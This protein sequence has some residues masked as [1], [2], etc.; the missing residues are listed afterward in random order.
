M[1][2]S[3]E[4]AIKLKDTTG[5]GV[6]TPN[7]EGQVRMM[8]L[9]FL[10]NSGSAPADFDS[11]IVVTAEVDAP[12]PSGIT[13]RF[14]LLETSA[15]FYNYKPRSE[16]QS[17]QIIEIDTSAGPGSSYG[18]ADALIVDLKP[19][20]GTVRAS[21]PDYPHIEPIEQNFDFAGYDLTPVVLNDGSVA[22]GNSTNSGQVSVKYMDV[23]V[24]EDVNIAFKIYDGNASFIP[25]KFQT[26]LPNGEL[27]VK[28]QK[29]ALGD[30]VAKFLVASNHPGQIRIS[31]FAEK[32]PT[33]ASAD[34]ILMFRRVLHT[35]EIII[36]KAS[37]RRDNGG[38]SG[39]SD[40]DGGSISAS[41][42]GQPGMT[43]EV[44]I[45][46]LSD[47]GSTT[48]DEYSNW[49]VSISIGPLYPGEYDVVAILKNSEGLEFSRDKTSVNVS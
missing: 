47:K 27:I 33:V 35:N 25:T 20:T 31:G 1:R 34:W 17:D 42:R 12:N 5:Q 16:P 45:S 18:T 49:A 39:I 23:P 19:E 6:P 29:N 44:S 46:S 48:V 28:T 4:K 43:V 22:D 3:K 9:K 40:N 30:A 2:V 36:D 7:D 41:G 26:L 8:G 13:V 21:L 24:E 11:W 10:P 37:G 32:Y 14:E 15:I 38:H